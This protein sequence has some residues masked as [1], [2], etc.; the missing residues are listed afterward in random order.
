MELL[1]WC[2][3]FSGPG[4][5]TVFPQDLL[6]NSF[7]S[8]CNPACLCFA[9]LNHNELFKRRHEARLNLPLDPCLLS[10]TCS[11]CVWLPSS[12]PEAFYGLCS[13][14]I[15]SF[16]WS[17]TSV[18]STRKTRVWL[19]A[20]RRHRPESTFLSPWWLTQVWEYPSL[21]VPGWVWKSFTA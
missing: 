5:K 13:E 14:S 1:N 2:L 4:G 17:K 12:E 11:L 10:R 21:G 16:C 15:H 6:L 8:L 3:K 18:D 20:Q 19:E 7:E 9:F